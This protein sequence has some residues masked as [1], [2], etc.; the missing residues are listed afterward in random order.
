[1]ATDLKNG[2]WSPWSY[3]AG[4]EPPVPRG[5]TVEAWGRD[6]DPPTE[7]WERHHVIFEVVTGD[8]FRFDNL[9]QPTLRTLVVLQYR[10]WIPREPE[11][12]AREERIEEFA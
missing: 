5:T 8:S 4:G 2:T 9:L 3:W 12:I 10:F 1:M 6:R 7:A 11:K